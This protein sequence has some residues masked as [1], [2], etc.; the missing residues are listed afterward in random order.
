MYVNV[1]YTLQWLFQL[2]LQIYYDSSQ[3]KIGYKG[4]FILINVKPNYKKYFN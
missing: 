2:P 4:V 3:D 1:Y